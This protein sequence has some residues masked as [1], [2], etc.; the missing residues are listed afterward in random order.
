MSI[1]HPACQLANALNLAQ[2]Q[3]FSRKILIIES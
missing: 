2:V 1:V 3:Q